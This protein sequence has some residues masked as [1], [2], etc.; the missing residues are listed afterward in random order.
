M[1]GNDQT[2]GFLRTDSDAAQQLQK[3][4]IE[5]LLKAGKMIRMRPQG[6]S[7]YPMIVSP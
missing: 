3:Y 4:D 7:M 1:N 6:T 5:A 2:E